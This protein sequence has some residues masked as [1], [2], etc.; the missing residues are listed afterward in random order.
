MANKVYYKID[1]ISYYQNKILFQKKDYKK[2]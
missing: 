2:K 1:Y